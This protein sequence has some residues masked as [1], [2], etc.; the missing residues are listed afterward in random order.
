MPTRNLTAT[1]ALAL[2]AL[3][4]LGCNNEDRLKKVEDQVTDLKV[5]VFKLRNQLESANAKAEEDRNAAA[6][7][8]TQD[9]RFQADLQETMRQLQDSTRVLNNRLNDTTV[10]ARV[11]GKPAAP[12]R[13]IARPAAARQAG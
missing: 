12:A 13:A 7:S 4:L 8:R 11:S 9:R 1:L 10:R 3:G 6:V 2:A 5:E